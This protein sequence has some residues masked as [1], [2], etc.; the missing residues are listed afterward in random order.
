MVSLLLGII[1]ALN[2]INLVVQ[3]TTPIK[4][5]FRAAAAYVFEHS[6]RPEPDSQVPVGGHP[7][8][9][10]F[11]ITLYLPLVARDEPAFDEL[12][13]FQIPYARYAFDFYF[14]VDLYPWAE[15]VYTNHQGADGT[16]LIGQR[17]VD[18]RMADMTWHHDSVWLVATE[19]DMWDTRRLVQAWL[20]TH[21]RLVEEAHF[22][23]VD[24]YRYVRK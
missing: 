18:R 10:T 2:G 16:F 5:D 12:I 7:S 14:P 22:N 23:R 20:E 21:M 6:S 1:L 15:G 4:A 19:V 11:P 8:A 17:E 13:V 24:V 9:S 3:A